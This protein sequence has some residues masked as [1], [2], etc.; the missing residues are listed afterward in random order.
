MKTE[1]IFKTE[2]HPE[3]NGRKPQSGDVQHDLRLPL[4]DGRELVILMGEKGFQQLTDILMDVLSNAE[5]Y[6]DGSTNFA[7]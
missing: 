3:A 7:K 1:V 2:D 6:N 5:P 4:E